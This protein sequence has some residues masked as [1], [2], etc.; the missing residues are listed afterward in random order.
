MARRSNV[1][2]PH[3]SFPFRLS[4]STPGPVYVD[5]D[6]DDE[7]MDC[8]EVYLATDKGERQDAPEYGLQDPTFHEGNID[9]N[10]VMADLSVWEPRASVG[11]A[12]TEITDTIQRLR[13]G[14]R[15][16]DDG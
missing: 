15:G 2:V 9:I 3:F 14:V 4:G 11:I 6:S 8:V 16:R 10:A 7:I 1:D 12:T 13:V 5:Q